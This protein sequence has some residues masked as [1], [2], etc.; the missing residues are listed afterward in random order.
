MRRVEGMIRM[1][2]PVLKLDHFQYSTRTK[3]VSGEPGLTSFIQD[4]I[5]K[6]KKF[7]VEG[8]TNQVDRVRALLSR[9]S[10]LK[11]PLRP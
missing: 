9:S 8:K 10:K 4:F 5:R 6:A 3:N 7:V 1:P 2:L 11:G